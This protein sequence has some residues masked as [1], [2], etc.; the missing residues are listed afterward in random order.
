VTSCYAG[1]GSDGVEFASSHALFVFSLSLSEDGMNH[2]Q[3][4][5]RE[6][7]AYIGMLRQYLQQ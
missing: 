3:E 4:V 5:C 7:F 6:V 2:W 1:V